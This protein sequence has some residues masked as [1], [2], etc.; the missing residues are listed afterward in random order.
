MR[1][2]ARAERGNSRWETVLDSSGSARLG[3]RKDV[4][5]ATYRDGR[6][7]LPI[8]AC[9][10]VYNVASALTARTCS[11]LLR[12]YVIPYSARC[13][14]A[15]AK[16]SL[17]ALWQKLSL[18]S[19]AHQAS[20]DATHHSSRYCNRFRYVRRTHDKALQL[21]NSG[22]RRLRRSIRLF[23]VK[24]IRVFYAG[25]SENKTETKRNGV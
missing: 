7:S 1:E 16:S 20:A 15:S 22:K 23:F 13:E 10:R 5:G 9:R 8:S 12:A 14:I 2:N 6:P 4:E 3:K 21:K 18:R 11:R 19:S 17:F 24:R 25:V